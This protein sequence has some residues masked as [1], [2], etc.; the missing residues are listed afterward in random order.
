MLNTAKALYFNRA[1]SED[2][3]GRCLIENPYATPEKSGMR[4]TFLRGRKGERC[5]GG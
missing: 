3:E 1:D 2:W 4:R 5:G